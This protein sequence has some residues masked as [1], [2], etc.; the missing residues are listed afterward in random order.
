MKGTGRPGRRSRSQMKGLATTCT[1]C[2]E[3]KR[4]M[5]L[6]MW[7]MFELGPLLYPENGSAGIAPRHPMQGRAKYL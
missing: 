2:S 7:H 3:V 5:T 6:C 1:N 4:A